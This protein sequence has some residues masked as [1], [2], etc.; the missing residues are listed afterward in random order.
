M[1]DIANLPYDH[2]LQC[3][4][5]SLRLNDRDVEIL[6]SDEHLK[7]HEQLGLRLQ[8]SLDWLLA[9]HHTI[10]NFCVAQ[11]LDLKN[12]SWLHEGQKPVTAWGFRTRLRLQAMYITA[13]GRVVLRF[14]D[15]GLFWGHWVVVATDP[16]LRLLSIDLEG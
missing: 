13:D 11:F 3:F 8:A 4:K 6:L 7:D 5:T 12:E 16:E 14:L 15:G 1:H 2:D 10:V 9:Q